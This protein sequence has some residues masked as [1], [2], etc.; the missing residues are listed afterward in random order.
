MANELLLHDDPVNTYLILTRKVARSY[1]F[2]WLDSLDMLQLRPR[3]VLT[4][5]LVIS[6]QASTMHYCIPRSNHGP[7]THVEVG[8]MKGGVPKVLKRYGYPGQGVIGFVPVSV[9]NYLLK[10]HG[11]VKGLGQ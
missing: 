9:V 1:T 5:R 3:L 2:Q 4:D 11:G 7:Y 6:V 8:V 10:K